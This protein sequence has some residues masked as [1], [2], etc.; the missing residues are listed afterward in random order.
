MQISI[1]QAKI[2]K[3]NMRYHGFLALVFQDSASHAHIID[4]L[5]FH[6]YRAESFNALA[7][8][9][10]YKPE[11]RTL[12]DYIWQKT[13]IDCN[14]KDS[15]LA[16]LIWNAMLANSLA[17]W[18]EGA[19]MTGNG[20]SDDINCY[21]YVYALLESMGLPADRTMDPKGA[22]SNLLQTLIHV[23]DFM[24]ATVES[25]EEDFKNYS[26]KDVLGSTYRLRERIKE[27]NLDAPP[28]ED[29]SQYN[30]LLQMS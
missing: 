3:P 10:V 7:C 18:Q 22:R 9:A 12:D 14:D 21:A 17:I 11:E 5:H 4:E 23:P 24:Q 28:R 26:M 13:A 8:P 15:V 25:L 2:I 19:P 6:G 30:L 16:L 1:Q 20:Y 29:H 27:C